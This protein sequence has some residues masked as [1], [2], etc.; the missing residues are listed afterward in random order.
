MQTRPILIPLVFLGSLCIILAVAAGLILRNAVS[1]SMIAKETLVERNWLARERDQMLNQ[2]SD[3]ED[4]YRQLRHEYELLKREFDQEQREIARL[5]TQL[6]RGITVRE[7]ERYE[8][9]INELEELLA[10]YRVDMETLIED[11]Q[12]MMMEGQQMASTLGQLTRKS[13]ELERENKILQE[14]V[15]MARQ[16]DIANGSVLTY[17]HGRRLR[18]TDRAS[19]VDV[20]QVCFEVRENPIADAGERTVYYRLIGP[21]GGF[22]SDGEPM[23][24][25]FNNDDQIVTFQSQFVY[26]NQDK[27][28]CT[29]WDG[30][31]D[32]VPGGHQVVVFI[33]DK[34][35]EPLFFK[36]R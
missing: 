30:A 12:L 21:D 23:R 4:T 36:L 16:L 22:I 29:R 2:L 15:H 9:R 11:N 25:S 7:K 24:F 17:I 19:R 13:Q 32:F 27:R 31:H 8:A 1:E 26:R 28:V 3:L 20:I 10:Q 6:A 34:Q 14:Q 35:Y 33:D 18:E 5:R